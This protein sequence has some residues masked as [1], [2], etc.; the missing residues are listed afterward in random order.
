MYGKNYKDLF[1]RKQEVEERIKQN[2]RF[3]LKI[4][5]R[6]QLP[7]KFEI[8]LKKNLPL[9]QKIETQLSKKIKTP[10]IAKVR[11]SNEILNIKRRKNINHWMSL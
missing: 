9:S 1:I 6:P 10:V 4:K 11:F 3:G 8:S 2:Q 7:S 5:E